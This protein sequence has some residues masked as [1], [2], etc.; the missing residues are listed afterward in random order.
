MTRNR[1][2]GEM[3]IQSGLS[4]RSLRY[5]EAKGLISQAYRGRKTRLWG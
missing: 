4:I 1:S 5:L 3:S 2:I